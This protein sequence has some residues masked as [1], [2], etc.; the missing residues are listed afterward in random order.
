[1]LVSWQLWD[2]IKNPQ[3]PHK[4]QLFILKQKFEPV[5][6]LVEGHQLPPTSMPYDLAL[7]LL[8]LKSFFSIWPAMKLYY[9]IKMN[10]LK[11][12]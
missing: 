6:K 8:N 7:V 12:F 4:N 11:H 5:L 10:A 2:Q 1:M 9:S 3:K